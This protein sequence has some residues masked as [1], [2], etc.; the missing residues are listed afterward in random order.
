MVKIMVQ[1]RGP[2]IDTIFTLGHSFSVFIE[3]ESPSGLFKQTQI[4]SDATG[5]RSCSSDKFP[6]GVDAGLRTTGLG[7]GFQGDDL[8]ESNNRSIN[9]FLRTLVGHEAH[10]DVL[11]I[12]TKYTALRN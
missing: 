12:I 5:L 9:I 7:E 1:A 2:Y 6:G 11:A 8:N 3:S 4:V 10:F